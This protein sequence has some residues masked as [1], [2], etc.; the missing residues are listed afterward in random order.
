MTRT[1]LRL[2]DH[3]V[4]LGEKVFE[5]WYDGVLIGQITSADGCGIKV[6]SKHRM[7]LGLQLDPMVLPI[8]I[9]PKVQVI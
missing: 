9:D 8:M 7:S 5:L 1:E 2:A 3:T 6:I 4:N